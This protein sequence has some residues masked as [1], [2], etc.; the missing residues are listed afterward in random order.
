MKWSEQGI[1]SDLLDEN[2][3]QICLTA[4][5]AYDDGLGNMVPKLPDGIYNCTR[6]M[7]QLEEMSAP[8]ET[9]EVENVPGHTGILF[10]IGNY[11]QTDSAGCLLVGEALEQMNGILGITKSRATFDAFML[12][13]DGLDSFTLTVE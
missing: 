6:G 7:H 11:A 4:E 1:F 12:L 13:Q 9:F 5:H 10:H 2:N 3:N 8:F